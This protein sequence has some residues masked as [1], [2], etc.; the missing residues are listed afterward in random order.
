MCA[1]CG[2]NEAGFYKSIPTYCKNCWKDKVKKR[3]RENPAVQAYDRLRG[4]R[5]KKGYLKQY[6]EKN[7]EKYKAQTA[8]NNAVRDG[9]VLKPSECHKCKSTL[10]I[11]GHHDDYS[12]PLDV[13]WMCS[14][15]H[16]R[17]HV[18]N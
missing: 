1:V 11:E 15:C 14:A 6:R 7:P 5:Q 18:D 3:R 4:N 9:K 17:L 13:D 2:S 10:Q 8:L 16:S 12:K